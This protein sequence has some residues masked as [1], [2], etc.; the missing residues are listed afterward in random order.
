MLASYKEKKFWIVSGLIIILD[1]LI[2]YYIP[3]YFNNLNYLYPMLT[4]SL[5]PFILKNNLK[6]YYKIVFI[7]GIIYDIFYSNIFLLNALVFLIIGRIDIKV[8]KLVKENIII[9][10][11]LVILNIMIYDGIMF[12]LIYLTNY[13]S[14]TLYGYF[15]KVKN[16]IILNIIFGSLCYFIKKKK[17]NI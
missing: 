11:C 1:G 16:S 12:S 6:D 7:L 10:L 9:Y 13:E 5:I 3:S 17:T 2:T 8:L 4:I 14:I 15:Y